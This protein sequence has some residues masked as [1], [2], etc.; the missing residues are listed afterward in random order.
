MSDSLIPNNILIKTK[1]GSFGVAKVGEMNKQDENKFVTSEPIK[2][3]RTTVEIPQTSHTKASAGDPSYAKASA[4]EA[5]FYFSPEDE[6]E[7]KKIQ[8][9]NHKTLTQQQLFNIVRAYAQAVMDKSMLE[10][11]EGLARRLLRII[12]SRL[13]DVRDLIETKEVLV[14]S[15][16][17]G[18]IGLDNEKSSEILRLIEKERE[19][20]QDLVVQVKD[21]RELSDSVLPKVRDDSFLDKEQAGNYVHPSYK[22]I[23]QPTVVPKIQEKSVII[24]NFGENGQNNDLVKKEE[25]KQVTITLPKKNPI[26]SSDMINRRKQVLGPVDELGQMDLKEFRNLGESVKE[27]VEKIAQKLEILEDES[28]EVKARGLNA[29]RHSPIYQKYLELGRN[30]IESRKSV[31]GYIQDLGKDQNNLTFEEFEAIADLNQ[32]LSF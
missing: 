1:G 25:I 10:L 5:N 7:I 19:Q 28:L 8:K 13:R 24:K 15:I 31:E 12:E 3:V 11:S 22:S 9:N 32:K 18:G 2:P 17:L 6:E 14:R 16:E 21:F 4:G 23:K 20:I 29:W 30:S 27:S 26:S